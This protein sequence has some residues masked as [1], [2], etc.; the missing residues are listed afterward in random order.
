[1]TRRTEAHRARMSGDDRAAQRLLD[2]RERRSRPAEHDL[3]DAQASVL[4]QRSN[5]S[6]VELTRLAI[7]DFELKDD[8]VAE[9]FGLELARLVV[10]RCLGLR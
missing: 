8:G 1:M 7:D 10:D 3:L 5:G 4:W 9:L 6:L 2:F